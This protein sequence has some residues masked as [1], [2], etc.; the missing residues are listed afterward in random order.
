MIETQF[1]VK[2]K[3]VRS[4]NGTEFTNMSIQTFFKQ[5]GI[6]HET[7]CVAT[8]QQNARVERKHRHI[9]N[10]ARALRFQANLPIRF[11]GECILA[12]THIINRTPT[13]ANQGITPYEV[14]FRNSP[15]YDHLKI[16]GCLCY[17]STNTKLRDKFDPRA[18]RCIFVGYP[19]GQKGWKVYNPKT[20]KFFVS[21]DVV[22]YENI[23][24]YVV[25]EKE[26]PIE[27]PSVVFH[28]ISGQQEES[29]H[30]EVEKYERQENRGQGDTNPAEMDGQNEEPNDVGIEVHKEKETEVPVHNEMET[31]LPPRTR[32]PPGYLQDYH[33]YTS[34][35][36]PISMPKTQSHSSGKIYPITNFISNDCYSRRHQAYLAAIH[37]TKEPQS[38][39]EAVKKTEWKE[40]MAAELKALEENGTWDLEL[41]PTCKKIVGCKWVYKVKYKATGEVEKYKARLVAKG[42]TQVEGE[43]FNETFAPVA[44]MTTVRCLLTVAVAKGWELHQMDVSNAFLHGD[45]DEEVYMQVPE[46]YHT[47]KAGMVCRLRKSLYGLKQAS[48]NWY[49]KLSHA[50]IEYG[51]QESHADHSLFTYSREG[52]FMAVLVYVDDLVIAGN[53]SDTC[54]NFKQYLRRCFHMKD[55]GPLK[56][57]LGLE[58]ARGA[59]GLFMCQRKYIMDILDECKM[60]DSKPSTFPMEQNQKLA[61]DTGPAYSDPPRYRRLVG[62]LIYLTI[63]R[64][65]ITY[66]VHILSQFTQSPQQA[67]WDAAMR[68]LRYLK[69]TPGQG[70]ILPKENDLQLVAYCDSDWASCPLTRRST[71]GYLMKLGSAPI[72]W[73]T[74]KQS[75][76]SKSSSEAEYRAMGQAVSEVIWLRS[77]LSSLQVHYKSPTVLFCDN[78]AAIHLAANPVYHERTK[79]IEVDCHFIRTHLQKG[80]ISTN[81]VST[82]KQQAD[83]FTKALGAKQFQELTFKLGAHNPHTPT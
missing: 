32:Q 73:K 44:K 15:T 48:R 40:A 74:K 60:L 23:L 16:F 53:Y 81:Y 21:R 28:E 52:E 77:L 31:D 34:H 1:D 5:K 79:H 56:Y 68:V 36:N 64:P 59:T 49:S 47:P 25:H 3:R 80:T 19:Q 51:F 69:F 67:H 39:R 9:L 70:I 8:P 45:L 66:S 62:R 58:L 75:T 71:S 38:Y 42:Y 46:G 76:V 41:P 54:T 72:S 6:I 82:K 33:C 63:T 4:D 50:L 37:N 12:A 83:I 20:Q 17:V 22:F 2:I 61:L 57:F 55:L 24:P 29:N 7:S 35:K 43:D 11:W 14:L 18:E 26:L 30:D 10:I 13:V 78:Q 27:S 65:E